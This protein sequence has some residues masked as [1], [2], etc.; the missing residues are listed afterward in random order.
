M[1][2]A[3]KVMAATAVEALMTPGLVAEAKAD[4]ARRTAGNPYVCPIPP[5]VKPPIRPRTP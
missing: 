1:V 4:H 2:H 5:D 3:A